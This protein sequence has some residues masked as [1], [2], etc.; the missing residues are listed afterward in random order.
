MTVVTV[1]YVS[2][3]TF[4]AEVCETLPFGIDF[5]MAMPHNCDGNLY[6]QI[7][8]STRPSV[9]KLQQA[10]TGHTHGRTEVPV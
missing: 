6:I 2:Y 10:L 7:K 4:R 5:K 1:S 3:G 8:T 9:L